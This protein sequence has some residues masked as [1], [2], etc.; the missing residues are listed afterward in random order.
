MTMGREFFPLGV[1]TGEAF[2]DREA[3]RKRLS[4]N[5]LGNG[6]TWLMA[7]RRFGKTSLV[8]QVLTE[9]QHGRQPPLHSAVVDLLPAYDISSAQK[10]IFSGVGK[11]SGQILTKPER[12]HR[13]AARFF[14]RLKPEVTLTDEGL[15]VRLSPSD[16]QQQDIVDALMG[17]DRMAGEHNVRAVLV[18]DEFQQLASL[19]HH[20]S[21]EASIRHAVER[22]C[23]VTYVFS[24][25]NRHILAAMFEDSSRPLYRLC[26][27]M[28]LE[29]ISEDDYRD[30]L[31]S[32]A[33][34]RW[35]EN[36]SDEV[37]RAIY[38]VTEGHPYYVTRL[39]RRLWAE[40]SVPTRD[41]VDH[42]WWA[43]VREEHS[44]ISATL[45]GLRPN[46]RAIL[47]ALAQEPTNQPRSQ[48]FL[49][50][51]GVAGSSATLAIQWLTKR[52]L[53][54]QG[55]NGTLRVLDPAIRYYLQAQR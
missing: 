37:F 18:F 10:P 48:E 34:A 16:S 25:S 43:H 6:H 42:E 54:Q 15:V 47:T 32:K 50:R 26:E 23:H 28:V 14:V 7:P 51:A 5:M 4:G 53:I 24:G 36:L 31:A 35:G 13:A 38:R 12:L 9:L 3:E 1:A 21:L 39:C 41:Q 20:A 19:P 30:F 33:S 17:L 49:T 8:A 11:L 55:A 52:D 45:A 29:A 22:A 2:C 27:R 40:S 44:V 46:Q